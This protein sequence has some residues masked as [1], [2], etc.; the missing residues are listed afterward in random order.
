M[1]QSGEKKPPPPQARKVSLCVLFAL[2]YPPIHAG[3][4]RL[5]PNVSRR[6]GKG[7]ESVICYV[8]IDSKY[9]LQRIKVVK[10]RRVDFRVESTKRHLNGSFII[11]TRSDS[12]CQLVAYRMRLLPLKKGAKFAILEGRNGTNI[13]SQASIRYRSRSTIHYDVFAKQWLCQ[14]SSCLSF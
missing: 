14:L 11:C 7:N 5:F 10:L 3:P 13:C 1:P 8:D 12:L 9:L 6:E 4:T 2:T